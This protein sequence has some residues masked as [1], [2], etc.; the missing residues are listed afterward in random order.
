MTRKLN[1]FDREKILK[2]KERDRIRQILS[3]F[4]LSLFCSWRPCAHR[5][6]DDAGKNA[7][8]E[9]DAL[10]RAAAR[11]LKRGSEIK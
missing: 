2:K 6:R 1:T 7:R 9:D 8:E 4:S 3:L 5:E 11:D 10:Y